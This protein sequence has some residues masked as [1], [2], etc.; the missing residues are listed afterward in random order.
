MRKK[1]AAAPYIVPDTI[2]P[3]EE[4]WG[5]ET[6]RDRFAREALNGMLASTPLCDRTKV[7]KLRWA[8]T[9]YEFAD[10]MLLAREKP[11]M[12]KP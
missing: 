12:V 3:L 11:I 6:M 5:I 10:A 1:R 4:L 9:A 7:K 2:K 8:T